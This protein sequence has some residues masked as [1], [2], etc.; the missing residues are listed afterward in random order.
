MPRLALFATLLVGCASDQGLGK[1]TGGYGAGGAQ[2]EVDPRELDFGSASDGEVV[3]QSFTITNVGDSDSMLEVESVTIGG[4][5]S[6]FTI[7]GETT[8][9]S[10]PGGAEQV[11]EVAFTALGANAQVGQAIVDSNDED[12]PKVP[13]DLTGEGLVPELSITPDPLE[14]DTVYVGC[15]EG[16][17]VTLANVGTDTL[18]LS[19][20][21]LSGS[22][23]TLIDLN[24]LPLDLA[25]GASTQVEVDFEPTAVADYTGLLTVTSNEPLGQRSADVTGAGEYAGEYVDTFTVPE[26]PPADI[27]F[28]VDQSCSMDDDQRNLASNF[29]AFIADLS[30]YTTDWHVLVVNDDDGCN[31]SG[32]LTSRTSDY[33]SRFESAVGRGGGTW[34]EA[35][36]TVTSEAIE[37]TDSG[38]CNDNF[39]RDDALLHIIMVSDEVEQ[40]T[41]SWDSY[42]DRV[43]TKKGDPNLVKFSAVAGDYPGGCSTSGNSAEA[44]VGYYEA[45][46]ETG[47][48]FLSICSTWSSHVEALATASIAVA[49]YTLEHTP[50]PSTIAVKVD[51]TTRGSGVWAYD[52]GTNAVTF[53]DAHIPESGSTVEISYAGYA[54]CD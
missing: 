23:M 25:P 15:G 26:D 1:T 22:E 35:G 2:I 33:D 46:M 18:T 16:R 31:N 43:R 39:L 10:L 20:I 21:S 3:T 38:E 53:D 27:L 41:R 49:S 32:V 47:G 12:N 44:G 8:S 29:S 13:V 37:N 4:G 30:N 28:Y 7:L 40:S 9:F 54:N 24:T 50:I 11:V 51:G 17:E 34:T 36:L 19:A 45:V 6:S 48:E 42:V 14:F 5:N 52:S